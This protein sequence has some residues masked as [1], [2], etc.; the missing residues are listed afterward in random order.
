MFFLLFLVCCVL[1]NCKFLALVRPERNLVSLISLAHS[2]VV[3]LCHLV[4]ARLSYHLAHLNIQMII[5]NFIGY[6]WRDDKL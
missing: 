5:Q 3:T 2:D 1:R 4:A 6:F